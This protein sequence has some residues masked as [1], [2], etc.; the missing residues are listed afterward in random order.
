MGAWERGEIPFSSLSFEAYIVVPGSCLSRI[1]NNN[2]ACKKFIFLVPRRPSIFTP[3]TSFEFF[4][5]L[6]LKEKVKR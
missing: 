1:N 5:N 2:S 4:E 6:S 3:G